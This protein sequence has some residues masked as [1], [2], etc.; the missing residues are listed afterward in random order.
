MNGCVRSDETAALRAAAGGGNTE[1]NLRLA[2][3]I[4]R[5]KGANVAREVIEAAILRG[6]S[7]R[8]GVCPYC[9]G[10]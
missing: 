9:T 6:T 5:A 4:D 8:H 3:A 1:T 10:A 2:Y 7:P